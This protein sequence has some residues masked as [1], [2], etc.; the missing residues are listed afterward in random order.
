MTDALGLPGVLR[1][2]DVAKKL[3][4][5]RSQ[6]G[7]A[8]K[9][10]TEARYLSVTPVAQPGSTPFP[11]TVIKR[12]KASDP[13]WQLYVASSDYGIARCN[14]ICRPLPHP[15]FDSAGDEHALA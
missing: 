4:M 14:R 6:T 9:E 7:K 5:G 13:E 1:V 11:R 8:L 15:G 10:L 12:C 3:V 2:E